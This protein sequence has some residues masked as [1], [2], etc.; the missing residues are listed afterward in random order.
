[1]TWS[2]TLKKGNQ[3]ITFSV[4]SLATATEGSRMKHA[5]AG[6]ASFTELALIEREDQ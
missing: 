2:Q 4:D 6:D 1:M 5:Q 3:T